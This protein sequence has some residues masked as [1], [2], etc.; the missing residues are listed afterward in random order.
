MSQLD[1]R[2]TPLIVVDSLNPK[3]F[4]VTAAD[5]MV[6]AHQ[7]SSH[8]APTPHVS[9]SLNHSSPTESDVEANATALTVAHEDPTEQTTVTSDLVD[10]NTP[11]FTRIACYNYLKWSLGRANDDSVCESESNDRGENERGTR[12][13]VV[14]EKGT[15]KLHL[16][17]HHDTKIALEKS[18]CAA[19]FW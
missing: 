7:Q 15:E 4:H 18:I 12:P 6:I 10:A 19:G 2:I 5:T 17:L 11:G 16:Q 3:N 1:D 8:S 13:S 14:N 9:S